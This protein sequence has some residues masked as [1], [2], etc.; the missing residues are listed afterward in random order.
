MQDD[1]KTEKVEKAETPVVYR[2]NVE[3]GK[4][5]QGKDQKIGDQK[6]EKTET[7][8]SDSDGVRADL[9]K[10]APFLA[11]L[12]GSKNKKPAD[13]QGQ[14]EKSADQKSDKSK[15]SDAK[16]GGDDKAEKKEL[17][18]DQVR[19]KRILGV[20]PTEPDD[21]GEG[22]DKGGGDLPAEKVA[23]IAAAAAGKVVKEVVRPAEKKQDPAPEYPEEYKADAPIYD[24]M[25]QMNPQKYGNL[26][27]DLSEFAVRESEYRAA[28]E[29]KN[30]GETFDPEAAE[31]SAFYAKFTP[32]I[33]E[34][35]IDLAEQQIERERIQ[36]EVDRR[37]NERIAP[38][39]RERLEIQIQPKIGNS[40][41]SIAQAAISAVFPDLKP[42]ELTEE[43][44]AE[45]KEKAPRQLEII[46]QE[47]AKAGEV[48]QAYIRVINGIDAVNTQS[49][50]HR[51][52]LDAVSR[53]QSFILSRPAAERRRKTS[54]GR[55]VEFL[56]LE[57]F[58]KL[59]KAQQSNYWTVGEAEVVAQLEEDVST[60]TAKAWGREKE[61][62][63]KYGVK[64][65]DVETGVRQTSQ[66]QPQKKIQQQTQPQKV[67]TSQAMAERGGAGGDSKVVDLG[68]D[69]MFGRLMRGLQ[70][71]KAR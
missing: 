49:P 39:Q 41:R 57:E 20:E 19:A 53:V 51:E 4:T 50:V 25:A 61:I 64:L 34:K 70:G 2:L 16:G 54:D 55:T 9:T 12:L 15:E 30:D 8:R 48:A 71:G 26:K 45:L 29:A 18:A 62:L 1:P 28:W 67:K 43:S 60:N 17:T 46:D 22:S 35:D 14:K 6:T 36:E 47:S 42:D 24:R 59:P 23:E 66:T 11:S 65:D 21:K 69:T 37:V 38:I 44:F 5:D 13:G 31:H 63:K 32:D 27:K 58:A 40:L 33:D 56:R 10:A 7:N 52:M 68:G 3:E